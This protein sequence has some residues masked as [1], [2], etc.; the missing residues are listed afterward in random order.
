MNPITHLLTGWTLAEQSALEHRDRSLVT[1]AALAPDLDGLGMG[2]DLVNSVLSRP[3]SFFYSDW[4]HQLLHG[5]PGALAITVAAA[6][7]AKDRKKTAALAFAAAH[8]HFLCDLAGSRGPSST[9]IWPIPYLAPF[10]QRLTFEW[11]GQWELNAWP[12]VAVSVALILYV[13]WRAA[14]HGRSPVSLASGKAN[15]VFVGVAR[16]WASALRTLAEGDS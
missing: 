13:F 12:N 6:A 2:L 9:D 15:E 7:A 4:H 14:A 8:L 5:L 1:M 10:S 11:S 16:K 3:Q